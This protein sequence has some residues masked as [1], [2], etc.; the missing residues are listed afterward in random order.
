MDT[1]ITHKGGCHCGAVK[2]EVQAP[3]DIEVLRCSCSICS[4]TGHLHLIVDEADF[5]LL[6]GT[7]AITE[8]RFNTK[9]ARHLFCKKCGV[10]PFYK[11]RSHPHGWSVN[12]NVL[13]QTTFDTVKV[14]E[15][16]GA[17]WEKNIDQIR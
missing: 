8:Y 9:T 12:L 17:N 4:M 16:D 14:K 1:K 7:D 10:K 15:F 6:E 5:Q 13:D 2:L 3:K 11:P